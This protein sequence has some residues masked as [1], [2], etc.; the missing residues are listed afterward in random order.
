MMAVLLSFPG[1]GIHVKDRRPELKE[2]GIKI[3][4]SPTTRG[5]LNESGDSPEE[6]EWKAN[7]H[8]GI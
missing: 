7:A 3:T 2:E 4:K 6:E 8:P 5:A 1:G